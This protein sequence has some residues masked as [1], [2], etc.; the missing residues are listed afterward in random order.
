MNKNQKIEYLEAVQKIRFKYAYGIT[1]LIMGIIT[2]MVVLYFLFTQNYISMVIA[3]FLDS[4]FFTIGWK[5]VLKH[6]F[7]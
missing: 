5:I 2:F 1:I 7:K 4:I 6:Y 3:A